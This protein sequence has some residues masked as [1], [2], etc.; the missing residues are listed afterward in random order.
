MLDNASNNDTLVDGI[1]QHAQAEDI[2]INATWARL[3]CMPHTVHLSAVKASSF[4]CMQVNDIAMYKY[5]GQLL[6]AVGAISKA[7]SKKASSRG[8]NYQDSATA[9]LDRAFD[10][11]LAAFQDN[12]EEENMELNTD[13]S[14]EILPAVNKV[15]IFISLFL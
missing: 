7:E 6:E 2:Y 1:Q 9:P 10:D 12:N 11:V 8:S 15:L 13:S 14:H 5:F 4:M 3:R